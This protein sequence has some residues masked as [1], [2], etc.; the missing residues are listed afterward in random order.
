MGAR[1]IFCVNRPQGAH[2]KLRAEEIIRVQAKEDCVM[3]LS[4]LCFLF[5]GTTGIIQNQ[6]FD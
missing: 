5:G 6:K 2:Q 1:D 3:D 4:H